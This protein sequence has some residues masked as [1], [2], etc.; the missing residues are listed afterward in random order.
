MVTLRTP[1]Q[2]RGHDLTTIGEFD[3]PSGQTVPFVLTHGFS[4][5]APSNAIAAA[6]S[7]EHTEVFW[8]TWSSC[9]RSRGGDW[10]DAVSRPLIGLSALTYCTT[11]RP[12][13]SPRP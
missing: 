1:V 2:L 5:L 13:A 3:V 12:V 7:L 10:S 11:C 9:I 4:H 8:K 6:S